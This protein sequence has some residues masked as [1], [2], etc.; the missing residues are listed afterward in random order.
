VSLTRRTFVAHSSLALIAGLVGRSTFARQQAPTPTFTPLRRH[1]GVFTA[2]GGAVGY[3]VDARGVAV[4]DTQFANTAPMLIVGLN[5]R[6][7]GRPVD[8]LINT[9]HHGDHTGGNIAF[10]GLA[11]RVVAHQTAAA[12]MRQP[13]GRQ[14]P[15]GEQ[16]YPDTTFA[17]TWREEVGD[18]WIR[19]RHYGRA[20][21]S[22]D[23]VVTFERANV[24][25]MGDLM[26]NF[27]QPVVDRPAGALLRNW[28]GVVEKTAADHDAETIYI[29]GHAGA[30]APITGGRADLLVMR[31]YLT[32]LLDFVQAERKAGRSREQVVAIR[33]PVPKFDR[34]GPLTETVLAA[35]FDEL[36]G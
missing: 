16:L 6:S 5:E 21:T 24:A 15:A 3:L 11:A 17:D 13:P 33:T 7:K 36:A 32:A 23:A 22:G 19:A 35:A 9:H 20:H 4:V 1:V 12:H 34:H 26:F 31:D 29:F 2:S 25:H 28:I 30:G 27:R 14:A 8:R 18:E 10:K